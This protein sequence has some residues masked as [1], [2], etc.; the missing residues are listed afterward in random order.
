MEWAVAL[1]ERSGPEGILMILPD[2]TQAES[3]AVEIRARG[4]DV[5]VKHLS[6]SMHGRERQAKTTVFRP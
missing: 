2:R 4:H 1:R 3:I 6:T 5:V